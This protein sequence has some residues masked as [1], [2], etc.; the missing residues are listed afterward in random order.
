MSKSFIN[1]VGGGMLV[2]R[3][4]IN[5]GVSNRIAEK[6]LTTRIVNNIIGVDNNTLMSNSNKV[7]FDSMLNRGDEM[8]NLVMVTSLSGDAMSTSTVADAVS[9]KYAVSTRDT[10]YNEIS[11]RIVRPAS[12]ITGGIAPSADVLINMVR[13]YSVERRGA[14]FTLPKIAVEAIQQAVMQLY[15]TTNTYLSEQQ[16]TNPA[17]DAER[18]QLASAILQK[19]VQAFQGC[20]EPAHKSLTLSIE[21]SSRMAITDSAVDIAV[22][23]TMADCASSLAQIAQNTSDPLVGLR[24]KNTSRAVMRTL[25]KNSIKHMFALSKNPEGFTD[26]IT[27]KAATYLTNLTTNKVLAED[28]W[29][30]PNN[31]DTKMPIEGTL[32][33]NAAVLEALGGRVMS[34]RRTGKVHIGFHDNSDYYKQSG[35]DFIRLREDMNATPTDSAAGDV[36]MDIIKS[37]NKN[38]DG[39]ISNVTPLGRR[40]FGSDNTGDEAEMIKDDRK[41]YDLP[42]D[43]RVNYILGTKGVIVLNV[44]QENLIGTAG[45]EQDGYSLSGLKMTNNLMRVSVGDYDYT[46]PELKQWTDMIMAEKSYVSASQDKFGVSPL[47]SFT[48]DVSPVKHVFGASQCKIAFLDRGLYENEEMLKNI[49]RMYEQILD[50]RTPGYQQLKAHVKKV[51]NHMKEKTKLLTEYFQSDSETVKNKLMLTE[52]SPFFDFRNDAA[53]A[54]A[55]HYIS[56]VA[57]QRKIVGNLPPYVVKAKIILDSVTYYVA[58]KSI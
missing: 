26:H 32:L 14:Q 1:P 53:A 56:I 44:Q 54:L 28:M 12:I 17:M 47:T 23:D 48:P 5:A 31:G 29:V 36:M 50:D 25:V 41:L 10:L 55:P 37:D 8:N 3:M 30:V 58:L 24:A 51:V 22:L 43:H 15:N 4:G 40:I 20:V 46:Y 18:K 52:F 57:V 33:V 42:V 9:L 34:G 6:A 2:D 39:A 38:L 49:T 19:I 11:Q 35:R 27:K 45:P 7:D 16:M 21:A 13:A